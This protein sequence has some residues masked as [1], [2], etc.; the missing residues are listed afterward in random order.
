MLKNQ[1]KETKAVLRPLSSPCKRVSCANILGIY[2]KDDVLAMVVS[3][4]GILCGEE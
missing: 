4:F 3:G 1:K 2:T